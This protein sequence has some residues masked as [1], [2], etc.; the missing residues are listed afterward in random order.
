MSKRSAGSTLAAAWTDSMGGETR[1]STSPDRPVC[2][3][4]R[5][6]LDGA[7]LRL[8]RP[9]CRPG[10]PNNQSLTGE[11]ELFY[12]DPEGVEMEIRPPAARVVNRLL[13]VVFLAASWSTTAAGEP[14]P[15]C[16][17][18]NRPHEPCLL[19]YG[20][21]GI[22]RDKV[23]GEPIS[24]RDDRGHDLQASS[25]ADGSFRVEALRR[26]RAAIPTT[27]IR[28]RSARPATRPTRS[29]ITPPSPFRS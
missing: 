16:G 24:G 14:L 26:R 27:S 12:E 28:S 1:T 2:D 17:G 15:P 13:L 5:R 19:V 8:L 20:A 6:V 3:C 23:T 29:R 21:T 18:C 10:R 7:G 25:G 11:Q 9:P 4:G 22:V